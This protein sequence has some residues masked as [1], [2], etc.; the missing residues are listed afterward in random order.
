MIRAK[1]I[2]RIP[3]A[4]PIRASIKTLLLLLTLYFISKS[5]VFDIQCLSESA[6][7]EPAG[8]TGGD[9]VFYQRSVLVKDDFHYS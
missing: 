4:T 8:I 3:T 6:I 9:F 1:T 5:V 7:S 2:V